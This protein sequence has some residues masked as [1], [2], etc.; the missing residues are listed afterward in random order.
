MTWKE[1]YPV[2]HHVFPLH[3]AKDIFKAGALR[4]KARLADRRARAVRPTTSAVDEVLGFSDVVHLYL[5]RTPEA[6][7]DLPILRAQMRPASP[8]PFPH[9]VLSL[10]M[11]AVADECYVCCWNIAVS[12]PQT[13]IRGEKVKGGNWTRGTAPTRIAEVWA[14]FREGSPSM[15]RARGYWVDP[16][17][18]PVLQAQQLDANLKLL[19]APAGGPEL[20]IPGEVALGRWMTFFVFCEEDE[21]LLRLAGLPADI[22]LKRR[23]FPDYGGAN[24][25][26]KA[27]YEAIERYIHGDD[28]V[29]GGFD[30]VRG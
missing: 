28:V 8:P 6:F 4:S 10:P 1:A 19:G 15:E 13:V 24:V 30:T 2:A 25:P 14:A 26:S 17:K 7:S 29:V 27:T 20:L 11:G 12:R 22:A 23:V 21:R 3:A 16:M 9:A 18:V 5:R